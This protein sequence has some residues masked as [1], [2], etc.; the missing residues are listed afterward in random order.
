MARILA[1]DYGLKRCGIAVTDKS[2]LIAQGLTTVNADELMS[3]LDTYL[4]SEDVDTLVVGL[5]MQMNY[6]PSDIEPHIKGFIK[7]FSKKYP[8]IEICRV[9]ERFTSKMSQQTL[10]MAGASKKQRRDKGLIDT[11][12]ATIILQTFLN[13][14]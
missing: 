3:Y 13:Q 5:P 12:S 11:I 7:R 14:Q 4:N 1:I 10:I 9:D 2:K 8:A 6:T